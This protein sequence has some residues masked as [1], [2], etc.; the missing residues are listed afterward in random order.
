[1]PLKQS[2]RAHTVST[3]CTL[4][5][6]H[7]RNIAV[8]CTIVKKSLVDRGR[9]AAVRLSPTARTQIPDA[10]VV[11][12]HARGK[13]PVPK[14]S[15]LQQRTQR[16]IAGGP[17]RRDPPSP[18]SSAPA[19]ARSAPASSAP[20]ELRPG[21]LGPGELRPGAGELRPGD[22]R[23]RARGGGTRL[24]GGDAK[25][26]REDASLRTVFRRTQNGCCVWVVRWRLIFPRKSTVRYLKC[27]WVTVWVVCCR[28]S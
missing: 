25:G 23:P 15:R 4:K 18:A 19:R 10:F 24:R 28:Q 9:T 17:R 16:S 22:G 2:K 20:G 1:M 5:R 27:G 3:I 13:G 6:N 21:A 7:L 11:I 26:T 12:G 8:L 14:T